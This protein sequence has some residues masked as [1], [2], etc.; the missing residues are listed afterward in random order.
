MLQKYGFDGKFC[1]SVIK[2]IVLHVM[3]ILTH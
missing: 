3:V 2:T 1:T